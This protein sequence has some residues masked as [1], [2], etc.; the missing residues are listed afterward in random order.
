MNP[1]L[2]RTGQIAAVAVILTSAA[3]CFY[4]RSTGWNHPFARL[5]GAYKH[6]I[7]TLGD[8]VRYKGN[9]KAFYLEFSA[10]ALSFDCERIRDEFVRL[11][12]SIISPELSTSAET[13]VWREGSIL[14]L[15][16]HS[17]SGTEAFAAWKTQVTSLATIQHPGEAGHYGN[18]LQALFTSVKIHGQNTNEEFSVATKRSSQSDACG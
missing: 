17:V 9:P 7:V 1:L 11:T 16:D 12:Q 2:S 13:L 4:L 15:T 8:Y 14:H 10:V 3:T 18:L 6:H 5:I